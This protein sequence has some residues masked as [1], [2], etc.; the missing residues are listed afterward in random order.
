M[1]EAFRRRGRLCLSGPLR[2]LT[3]SGQEEPFDLSQKNH[4]LIRLSQSD[5]ES[6]RGESSSREEDE[7]SLYRMSQYSPAICNPETREADDEDDGEEED[8]EEEKKSFSD[9]QLYRNWQAHCEIC[10]EIC[11][12][13]LI[14]EVWR[15]NLFYMKLI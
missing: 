11:E 14:S 4:G 13:I 3:R 9:G 2:I 5:G 15:F 7:D 12:N 6:V 10:I 8:E 1:F